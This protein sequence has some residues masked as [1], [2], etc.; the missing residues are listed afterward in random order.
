M[1]E[2]APKPSGPTPEES[3]RI[4]QAHRDADPTAFSELPPS[5]LVDTGRFTNAY[6]RPLR[7]DGESIYAPI[8]GNGA[9]QQLIA[10]ILKGT[11][12]VADVVRGPDEN[13]HSKY[14]DHYRI[15]EGDTTP[16]L[17][18][19]AEL[20]SLVFGD[21]DHRYYP[22]MEMDRIE[23]NNMRVE[24]KRVSHYDFEEA[25]LSGPPT[26]LRDRNHTV[27]SLLALDKKLRA[28]EDQIKGV[29]GLAFLTSIVQSAGDSLD[30]M[31]PHS[32]ANEGPERL[33]E[34]LLRRISHARFLARQGVA[35]RQEKE[36]A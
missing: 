24:N 28:L 25:K 5:E 21:D 19:D 8:S 12:N 10:R 33:Q 34:T 36:S 30:N 35:E 6:H 7:T 22:S 20:L 3:A 23:H 2:G 13:F 29:S 4:T 15:R 11:L 27:E 1:T 17:L 9:R 31:F 18:A 26:E 16:E 32:D 14:L